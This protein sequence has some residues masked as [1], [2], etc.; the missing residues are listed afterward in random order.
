MHTASG[1][2]SVTCF[3]ACLFVYSTLCLCGCRHSVG[4]M[5]TTGTGLST[6]SASVVRW[7]SSES[8]SWKLRASTTSENGTSYYQLLSC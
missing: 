5:I 4:L 3:S 8:W 6:I 2:L 7:T 1:G